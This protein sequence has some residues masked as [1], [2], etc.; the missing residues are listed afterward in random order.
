MRDQRY[1]DLGGSLC[2]ADFSKIYLSL[3]IPNTAIR[4]PIPRTSFENYLQEASLLQFWE[5]SLYSG[6]RNIVSFLSEIYLKPS[7]VEGNPG[8]SQE[9]QDNIVAASHPRSPIPANHTLPRE[10]YLLVSSG[11]LTLEPNVSI[12]DQNSGQLIYAMT[13]IVVI[14]DTALLGACGS[15]ENGPTPMSQAWMP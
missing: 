15:P 12:H 2:F 8:F 14:T 9:L 11:S 5:T 6:V 3:E 13:K 4:N 10:R 7:F 1:L